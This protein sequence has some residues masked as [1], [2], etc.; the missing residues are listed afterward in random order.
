MLKPMKAAPRAVAPIS[1]AEVFSACSSLDPGSPSGS[2]LSSAKPGSPSSRKSGDADAEAEGNA[3][4]DDAAEHGCGRG[5]EPDLTQQDQDRSS[6]DEA[7]GKRR[8]GVLEGL[9]GRRSRALRN[10]AAASSTTSTT[11]SS[12]RM[13][14][15]CHGSV[16]GS[17]PPH[18]H[19]VKQRDTEQ[20]SSRGR[21]GP[22][23]GPPRSMLTWWRWTP[24]LSWRRSRRPP[25]SCRLASARDGPANPA[26]YSSS[27]TS[28]LLQA[29]STGSTMR[30]ACSVSSPLTDRTLSPLRASRRTIPYGGNGGLSHSTPDDRLARRSCSDRLA[31]QGQCQR[32]VVAQVELRVEPRRGAHPKGVAGDC[33]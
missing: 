27:G 1:A 28:S 5:V 13:T 11:N 18:L 16:C 9:P 14:S 29:S 8:N 17:D 10:P 4:V 23:Q 24:P 3:L 21:R 20:E 32:S 30:H 22:G 7:H 19:R 6:H 12:P 2:P 26:G 33:P 15:I 25:T 31:V